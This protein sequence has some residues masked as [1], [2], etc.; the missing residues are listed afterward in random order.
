M[1]RELLIAWHK[2]K[3]RHTRTSTPE[4]LTDVLNEPLFFN[5]LIVS[6]E[7]PLIYA[8]W[9]AAGLTQVKDIC[10]EAV[11]GLLPVAAIHDMLSDKKPRALSRTVRELK[12]LLSLIPR[13]WFQLVNTNNLRPPPTIQPSFV[14]NNPSPGSTPTDL[15]ACKTRTFYRH[16]HHAH[17]P[18]VPAVDRWKQLLQPTPVFNAKQWRTLYSP[19]ATNKQGDLNWK[20]AHRV[21]PT[22]LSLNKM[23]VYDSPDCH[24]C[25]ETDTIEHALLECPTVLTFWRKIEPLLNKISNS[26]LPVP[27]SLKALGKILCK[28]DPF[29]KQHVDLINWTLTIAR[30]AIHKSPVYHRVHQTTISSEAIFAAAVKSHLHFQFKLY[31]ACQTQFYFPYD[32]C[33]GEALAKI[34]NDK[35]VFTFD[36]T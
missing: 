25:G 9:I 4:S 5:E 15:L 7:K 13:Q 33:L 11:P 1:R 34:E 3:G 20:I 23:T 10:Y 31:S 29:S 6:Q 12:D 30:Y 16:L 36:C 14:I 19:L 17:K 24:R 8:D 26:N 32:W 21:L 27:D 22:A 2:H 18:P 35:I 28:N